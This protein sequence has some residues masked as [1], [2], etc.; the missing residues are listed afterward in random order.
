MRPHT[1]LLWQSC[2]RA[3]VP[4]SQTDPPSILCLRCL[5]DTLETYA[6]FWQQLQNGGSASWQD[7]L[8]EQVQS[9]MTTIFVTVCSSWHC[10]T[11]RMLEAGLAVAQSCCCSVATSACLLC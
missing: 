7:Y 6:E 5:Q 11:L 3:C 4:T 2:M 10:C 9:S 8:L 1:C